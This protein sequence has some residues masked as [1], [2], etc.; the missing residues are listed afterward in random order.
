[1]DFTII[2]LRYCGQLSSDPD[3]ILAPQL[4]TN[5]V[6]ESAVDPVQLQNIKDILKKLPTE[7]SRNS[8]THLYQCHLLLPLNSPLRDE[9]VGDAM[10]TKRLAKR[11]VALKASIILHQLK[12]LDD[13]HLFP[14]P[15]LTVIDDEDESTVEDEGNTTEPKRGNENGVVNNRR[16]PGCFSNCRPLSGRPCFVYAIDFTLIKPCLD[17]KKLYF[18]FAVETKLAILTSEVIPAI[19]PFPLVTRAGEFQVTLC[20]ADSVILNDRQLEKLEKFH[21]FVFQDVLFLWKRQLDFDV[22]ASDLQ[23]LVVPLQ[24]ATDKIDFVLVEKMISAPAIDWEKPPY[25]DNNFVFQPNLLVDSIIVPSYKP[26]GTL[27][28]FYVDRVSDLIPLTPFPNN[29]FKTYASYFYVKY[30][31]TLTDQKQ[32]LLQVSREISGKNFLIPR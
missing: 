5:K 16:L 4:T 20:G 11:A 32:Q 10:P 7:M 30:K 29:E 14:V 8:P 3:V 27:N 6:E 23:Y 25:T 12:E 1:M 22:S 21:R 19:C 2:C 18:P 17:I 26:L 24:T 31:L 28:A 13:N 9:V 15:R